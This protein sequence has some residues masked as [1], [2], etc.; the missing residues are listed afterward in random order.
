MGRSVTEQK[1]ASA[2]RSPWVISWVALVVVVLGVNLTMVYFAI[3]SNPGLVVDD[4]YERG[5]HYEHTMLSNMKH[6]PGWVLRDDIPKDVR[7][8]EKTVVRFFLVDK[9]GQPVEPDRVTFYAYRPSDASRDFKAAMTE[10][11]KGRYVAEVQFPLIGAWDTL[12]SVTKG[13]D[14]FNEGKR[15]S[16]ERP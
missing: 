1:S 12:F 2:W 8:G 15:I 4:Y 9:A 5:Q 14:E 3:A 13:A 16:V 11:G 6:R 7:A 10:E